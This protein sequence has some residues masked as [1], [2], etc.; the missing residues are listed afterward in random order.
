MLSNKTNDVIGISEKVF[1]PTY[2]LIIFFLQA[3]LSFTTFY[4]GNK[5]H[6]SAFM[7]GYHATISTNLQL[8][9]YSVMFF[10]VRRMKT[11][12][13]EKHVVEMKEK[14]KLINKRVELC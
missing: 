9:Y 11:E 7:Q 13:F 4:I 3:G 14:E 5:L 6:P 1:W 10:K 8:I 2:G 12:Y